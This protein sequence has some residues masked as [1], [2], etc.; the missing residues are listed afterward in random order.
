MLHLVQLN[1]N[2]ILFPPLQL[3]NGLHAGCDG[4][5]DQKINHVAIVVKENTL[6]VGSLVN[7]ILLA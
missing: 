2:P 4:G 7:R 5:D 3:H 1:P 6:L